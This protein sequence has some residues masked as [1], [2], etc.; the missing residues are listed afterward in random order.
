MPVVENVAESDVE[1][2]EGVDAVS[3]HSVLVVDDEE[4][5]A[6]FIGEVLARDGFTVEI[7]HSGA[8]AIGQLETSHYDVLLSDLNMPDLDGR[9]LYETLK[10][11]FPDMVPRTGFITGDTMG[12]ASQAVL[13]DS[14][15]PYLE[16]PVMPDDLRRLIQGI[17]NDLEDE[18]G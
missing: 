18:K 8:D 16:K 1:S 11:D 14:Q 7:A 15:R 17:L 9:S 2:T 13:Q 3:A 6:D 10:K 5:V 4:D 12:K